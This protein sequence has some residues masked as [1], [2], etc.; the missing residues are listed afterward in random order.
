[1]TTMA[2]ASIAAHTAS[3]LHSKCSVLSQ[4]VYAAKALALNTSRWSRVT[5]LVQMNDPPNVANGN[6]MLLS[7]VVHLSTRM[8]VSC[9]HLHTVC[10]FS[11]NDVESISQGNLQLRSGSDVNIGGLYFS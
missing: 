11:F 4:S 2:S 10:V 7:V 3:L 9:S 8:V 6:I 1:M 5:L